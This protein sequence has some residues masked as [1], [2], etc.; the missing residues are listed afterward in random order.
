MVNIEYDDIAVELQAL[1]INILRNDSAIAVLTTNILDGFPSSLWKNRGFPYI[2]V[3]TPM[4]E[5]Q[6]ITTTKFR[7]VANLEVEVISHEENI[8]RQLYDLVRKALKNN[9]DTTRGRCCYLY[10]NAGS[11][12]SSFPIAG[13]QA[14]ASVG[15]RIIVNAEYVVISK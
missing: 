3:H 10:R 13:D 2:L 11:A 6:R 9:Q 8:A 7:C 5:D 12:I 15:W 1:V 4:V 14:R